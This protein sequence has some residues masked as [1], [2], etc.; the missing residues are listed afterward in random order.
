MGSPFSLSTTGLAFFDPRR[1]RLGL[2]PIGV[3]VVPGA[4]A[5]AEMLT[6]LLGIIIGLD[7]APVDWSRACCPCGGEVGGVTMDE[8]RLYEVPCALA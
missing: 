5:L 7:A 8:P 3:M 2:T 6:M 1:P 4:Y